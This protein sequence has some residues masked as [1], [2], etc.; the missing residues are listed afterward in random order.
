L[1]IVPSIHALKEQIAEKNFE[2][3]EALH[4]KR[5]DGLVTNW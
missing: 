4:L 5:R 2:S 3:Q 1:V